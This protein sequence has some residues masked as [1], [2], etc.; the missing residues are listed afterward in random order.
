MHIKQKLDNYCNYPVIGIGVGAIRIGYGI[1]KIAQGFIQLGGDLYKNKSTKLSGK[2]IISGGKQLCIGLVEIVPVWG[3]MCA[4][5]R[6]QWNYEK[7]AQNFAKEGNIDQALVYINK[8]HFNTNRDFLISQITSTLLY[9][10]QINE[11]YELTKNWKVRGYWSNHI[12][13]SVV[14]KDLIASLLLNN[15][16]QKAE[17]VYSRITPQGIK[18]QALI[19]I[20][21]YKNSHPVG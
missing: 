2:K 4:D 12:N 15:D 5:S 17:D 18:A 7:K 14:Q 3:R 19:I 1:A 6:M 20:N 21:I 9:K 10:N 16:L 13:Y 8:I 11:A